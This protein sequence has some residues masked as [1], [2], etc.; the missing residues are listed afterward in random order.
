VDSAETD[1]AARLGPVFVDTVA[2]ATYQH[3][4]QRLEHVR[5]TDPTALLGYVLLENVAP[6]LGR[7]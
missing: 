6:G 3:K 7:I 4:S 2:P 1:P 5:V